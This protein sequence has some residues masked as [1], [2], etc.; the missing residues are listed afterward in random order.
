LLP[1][2]ALYGRGIRCQ[3]TERR[4]GGEVIHVEV[5]RGVVM[6]MA[7]WML[8][9]TACAAMTFG[10]PRLSISALAE[11]HQLLLERGFR[12]SSLDD[13]T[14]AQEEQDG[15]TAVTAAADR[16]NSVFRST[17]ES[18]VGSAPQTGG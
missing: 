11:L 1:W 2:H 4:A 7:A 10:A 13:S 17:P 3:Y 18:F 15:K 12:R 8:D 9:P 16:A 5:A 6:V 14:I